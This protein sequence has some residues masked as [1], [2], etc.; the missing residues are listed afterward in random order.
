MHT[1]SARPFWV[2]RCIWCSN[3]WMSVVRCWEEVVGSLVWKDEGTI[4]VPGVCA[5]HMLILSTVRRHFHSGSGPQTNVRASSKDY[6]NK[7]PGS[8]FRRSNSWLH[9]RHPSCTL[10]IHSDLWKTFTTLIEH[11]FLPSLPLRAQTCRIYEGLDSHCFPT[12]RCAWAAPWVYIL[13]KVRWCRQERPGSS[14]S[15]DRREVYHVILH[16]GTRGQRN[17]L[18]SITARQDKHHVPQVTSRR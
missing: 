13:P 3:G 5:K 6:R 14:L 9:G 1:V 4:Q 12:F 15:G 17:R 8:L 7:I 10:K 18:P 2:A 11:I 16:G